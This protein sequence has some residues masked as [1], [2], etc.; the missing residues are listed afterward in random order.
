VTAR[1]VLLRWLLGLLGLALALAGAVGLFLRHAQLRELAT[2]LG[3]ENPPD[4]YR[5]SDYVYRTACLAFIWL[6]G[7]FG[8]AATDPARYGAL[9]SLCG[10]GL[11]IWG[12]FA[13]VL[14]T[15]LAMPTR[16]WATNLAVCA[17]SGAVLVRLN[18]YARVRPESAHAT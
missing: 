13:A 18:R 12:G 14:G 7:F 15:W 3:A 2:V 6:G 8:I 4:Y 9:V 17:T 1:I 5:Y 16:V 11:V 10:W